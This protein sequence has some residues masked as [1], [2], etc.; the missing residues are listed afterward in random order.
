MIFSTESHIKKRHMYMKSR[1]MVLM[2]L[3]AGQQCKHRHRDQTVGDAGG[4]RGWDKLR[5]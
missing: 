1:K 5:E 2:N 4:Q 3:F